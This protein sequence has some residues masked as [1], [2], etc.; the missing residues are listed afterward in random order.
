MTEAISSEQVGWLSL[1]L[2]GSVTFSGIS[3]K[4]GGCAT[5]VSVDKKKAKRKH[6]N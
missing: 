3:D 1:F 4:N 2:K 6:G 5:S